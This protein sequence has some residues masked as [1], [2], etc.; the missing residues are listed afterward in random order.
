MAFYF[1]PVP[2]FIWHFEI[3]FPEEFSLFLSRASQCEI[4]YVAKPI[5]TLN[6]QC[7]KITKK[8]HFTIS[9]LTTLLYQNQILKKIDLEKVSI[10][11]TKIDF[12]EWDI[13]GDFQTG[14][15][16]ATSEN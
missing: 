4:G 13:F 2:K 8:S 11:V 6:T 15:F 1:T 12:W 16:D 14:C 7:L 9:P 3:W 5:K 10:L